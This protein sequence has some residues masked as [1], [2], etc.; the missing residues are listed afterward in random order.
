MPISLKPFDRSN[1]PTRTY[2]PFAPS[3]PLPLP[4]PL[5]VP[6]SPS[7][8][9]SAPGSGTDLMA[10]RA[11]DRKGFTREL[12]WL[13]SFPRLATLYVHWFGEANNA[14]RL[15]DPTGNH[16]SFS[17]FWFLVNPEVMMLKYWISFMDTNP[18]IA[19]AFAIGTFMSCFG[20]LL[21]LKQAAS[22]PSTLRGYVML[23]VW[24][25]VAVLLYN[26]LVWPILPAF[27]CDAGFYLQVIFSLLIPV[28]LLLNLT[29]S[30][31][32]EKDD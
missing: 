6:L 30:A 21:L 14:L 12:V 20:N 13:S 7:P 15:F 5:P 19:G 27:L 18:W 4:L 31:A 23:N 3:F 17:W 16:G 10:L 26:H 2:A 25:V 9:D 29:S 22:G 32:R 11:F 8:A 24:T 28:R 1:S